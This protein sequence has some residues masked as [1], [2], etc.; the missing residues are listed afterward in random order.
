MAAKRQVMVI[1]PAM[2]LPEMDT[3]NHIAELS[4]LPVSYHM[5]A[6]FGMDSLEFG[7]ART[8]IAGVIVL[9]SKANVDENHPW[10]NPLIDWLNNQIHKN[11]PV[12]GICYGHQLL[13]HMFGGDVGYLY[14]DKRKT[15][16]FRD[17]QVSRDSRLW[18]DIAASGKLYVSHCQVV[19]TLPKDMIVVVT[20]GDMPNYGI[21]H[22]KFP[23]W[24]MQPHPEATLNFIKNQGITPDLRAH[25]PL[26]QF[27]HTFLQR[28]L[29]YVAA[30]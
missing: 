28:F 29:S 7:A 6:I 8:P 14:Q 9:G 15:Q 23:V 22:Q 16:E 30:V 1:D 25:P 13:G 10:Q 12:L 4:S 11:V 18:K 21:E 26:L 17:V 27:G 3:S 5:P 2:R 19:K 24:G 20:S